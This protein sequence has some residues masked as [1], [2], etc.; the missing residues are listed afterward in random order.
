MNI[1]KAKKTVI[2]SLFTFILSCFMISEVYGASFSVSSASTIQKGNSAT[3]TVSGDVIGKF[4]VSS[5]NPGVVSTSVS[6][7][8][9]EGSVNITLTANNYGS[10]SITV[11]PVDVSDSLGNTFNG[12]PRSISVN[13]PV[14]APAPAPSPTPSPAPSPTKVVTPTNNNVVAAKS[15]NNNLTSLS[16]NLEGLSPNFDKTVTNYT[17]IVKESINDVDVNAVVEDKKSTISITGNKG[18]LVGNNEILITVTA[19]DGSTKVYKIIVTKT[20]ELSDSS[21]ESLSI[22]NINLNPAFSKDILEYDLGKIENEI[23]KLNLT[24]ATTN[25]NAKYEIIGNDNLKVGENI[26]KIIV[27][28]ENGNTKKEYIIKLIRRESTKVNDGLIVI[29]YILLSLLTVSFGDNNL[30][31]Y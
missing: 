19:E 10:A 3:I 8:W 4:S 17:L 24:I 14:P 31:I 13:V 16:L 29:N 12:S 7:I 9:L 28:S 11:T 30:L 23:T 5:S 6:S 21:L 2:I 22:E 20:N 1:K 15:N 25:K 27:T 18:L 26:V